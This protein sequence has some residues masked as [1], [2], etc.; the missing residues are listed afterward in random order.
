MSGATGSRSKNMA[1]GTSET[2]DSNDTNPNFL[3]A[4]NA[5][6]KTSRNPTNLLVKFRDQASL[7]KSSSGVGSSS[8]SVNGEL[9]SNGISTSESI[10]LLNKSGQKSSTSKIN[11]FFQ[12]FAKDS[13]NIDG[14]GKSSKRTI[15]LSANSTASSTI[16]QIQPQSVLKPSNL[17]SQ[18][19]SNPVSASRRSFL[20]NE[21][22]FNDQTT[23][24]YE[25][26][27]I[28]AINE[29][30]FEFY[31]AVRI[32]PGQNP[33]S[34]FIGW[35]TSRFKPILQQDSNAEESNVYRLNKFIRRCTITQ[36]AENGSIVESVSRQDAYMFCANDLLESMPDAESV[37]R[38][39]VNGLLIGCLC[40]ISTGQLSFFVNGREAPQKLQ[41]KTRQIESNE[42]DTFLLFRSN[43][44]R[45]F[46]RPFFSNRRSKKFFNSNSAE[47]K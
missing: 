18:A 36:T 25:H 15:K 13:P 11:N 22:E 24:D 27:E 6:T 20:E 38:R 37:A 21:T 34:V 40:D 33:R 14:Q 47:S 30:V 5:V 42:F 35:V 17:V 43:R 4:E 3:S 23:N 46:I 2:L 28:R 19:K 41:V 45:N 16:Q 29:H 10:D 39:V 1:A 7:K 12:R 9:L 8:P 31:F 26:D 44:E 32:L